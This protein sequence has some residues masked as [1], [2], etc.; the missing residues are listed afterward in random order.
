MI[1]YTEG[2]YGRDEPISERWDVE[3]QRLSPLTVEIAY[4][5]DYRTEKT[6]RIRIGI[7]P[8]TQDLV[9]HQSGTSA[10]GGLVGVMWECGYLN[11]SRLT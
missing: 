9:I 4:H 6:I 1:Q 11:S 5:S 2:N 3:T 7:D 10:F 8:G